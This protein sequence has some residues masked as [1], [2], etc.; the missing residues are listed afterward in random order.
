MEAALRRRSS[1]AF[2]ALLVL[3]LHLAGLP[4][5]VLVAFLKVVPAFVG[6]VVW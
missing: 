2:L 1:L 6:V 3:L 4:T 5:V